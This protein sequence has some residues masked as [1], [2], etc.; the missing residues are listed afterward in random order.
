MTNKTGNSFKELIDNIYHDEEVAEARITKGDIKIVLKA[1]HIQ[2]LSMLKENGEFNFWGFFKI[3][4]KQIGG[5]T[6]KTI[7]NEEVEIKPFYRTYL[8][9]SKKAK[10]FLNSK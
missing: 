1:F 9:L 6:A 5:W 10:D 2:A 7:D 8:S 4:V 3:T